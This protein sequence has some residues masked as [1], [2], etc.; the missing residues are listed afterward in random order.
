MLTA[1]ASLQQEN[2][3]KSGKLSKIVNNAEENLHIVWTSW[4]ISMRFSGKMWLM[5]ILK[6]TKKKGFTFF[7][8]NTFLKKP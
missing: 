6:F 1:L 8:K 2:V 5:I 3:K 4:E 7:L